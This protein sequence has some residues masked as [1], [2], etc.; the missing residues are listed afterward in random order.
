MKV[1][2]SL[3]SV[4][5][6]KESAFESAFVGIEW[7][8]RMHEATERSRGRGGRGD[9]ECRVVKEPRGDGVVRSSERLGKAMRLEW[10]GGWGG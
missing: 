10:L 3:E 2:S 8:E 6:N 7:A 9:R 1:I 5:V 4:E